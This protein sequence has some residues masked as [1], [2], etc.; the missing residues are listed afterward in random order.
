MKRVYFDYANTGPVD[1]R[2]LKE[3][4]PYFQEVFGNPSSLHDFGQTAA[5]AVDKAREKVAGLIGSSKE[6]IIFTASS[7]E[8]N[9]FALKGIALANRRR[10]EHIVIS[11]IEHF[12]VLHPAKTLEKWG[13]E[14]TYLPVDKYG[15]VDPSRVEEAIT[16]ETILIS[17]MHANNEIGTIEPIEEISKVARKKGV[18]LHSDAS[19]T[20]GIIPV[21]VQKLGVD[22]LTF[23]A[24]SLYG[25][26]GAGV[27]F[28]KKGVR[29]MPLMEGGIQEEGRRPGTENVPAI[30]GFGKASELAKAELEERSKILTPLRHKL[31]RKLPQRI[32]N[33]RIN[34]HPE[35]RLPNNVD[36]CVE[37]IE[38]ESILMLLN[39]KGIAVSSGSACTSRALKASHVLTA[40][41]VPAAVAQ[42]SLLFSLGVGNNE[43]EVDYLLETLPPIVERL[44]QMS[45]LYKE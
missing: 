8:A 10:G 5:E 22:A 33:L 37:F 20:V 14:V 43:E 12:S 23:S 39:S 30:V 45:P 31:M 16:R 6:E 41:G 32:K 35:R 19:A 40:I 27:L 7:T 18:Y 15:L 3:M 24:Q 1:P 36:V 4:M 21:N 25:P 26:K 44:R 13:F 28:L 11:Q 2:V 34:G 38:G 17:I 9:N 29:I 42:G